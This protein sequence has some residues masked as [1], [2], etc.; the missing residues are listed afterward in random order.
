MPRL[1]GYSRHLVPKPS[2]WGTREHIT[3][4]WFL[5]PQTDWQLPPELADFLQAGPPPVYV[6]FGSMPAEDAQAQTAI[7]AEAIKRSGQ[8]ALLATGWGGLSGAD[9]GSRVHVIEHAPHGWLFPRCAA[10]VHHGGAGT[11]HEGLRWG[12]P[13]IVCPVGVDQPFWG[14]RVNELGA[15][16]PPILQKHLDA[17]T[18][19]AALEA[20]KDPAMTMRAEQAGAAM[21]AEGGAA[22]A[23]A[24]IGR[25]ADETRAS[26]TIEVAS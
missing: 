5:Q 20:V 22:E 15:G 17:E 23:A 1:H 4:C 2:D 26:R 8:R 19:T 18:L 25:F 10:V 7:V 12:R 14:R 11:T 3:G 21:R 6:G 13:S 24:V 16:P 9:L